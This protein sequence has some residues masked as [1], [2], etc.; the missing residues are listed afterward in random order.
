VRCDTERRSAVRGFEHRQGGEEVVSKPYVARRS[1]TGNRWIITAWD[2]CQRVWNNP[3]CPCMHSDPQFPDC[4]PGETKR[5]RGWLSFHEGKDVRA[6]L[7]R[8]EATGWRK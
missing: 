6:E 2:P 4:P 8:I 7:K 5:L 1:S 3:P